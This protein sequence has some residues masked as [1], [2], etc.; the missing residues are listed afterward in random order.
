MTEPAGGPILFYDGEC[1]LC[2]K[3]VRFVYTRDGAGVFRYAPLQGKTAARLGVS[4]P[5]PGETL[6]LYENGAILE[7]SD[8]V[9]RIVTLLGGFWGWFR[10]FRIVP[11]PIR[12]ALYRFVARIRFRVF[13][14][15]DVC[16]IPE[17]DQSGRLLD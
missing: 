8:A 16:L 13:G 3:A 15:S 5:G 2:H 6:V 9:L 1:A 17:R 11:R 14:K 7:R 12:D 4:G 10:V